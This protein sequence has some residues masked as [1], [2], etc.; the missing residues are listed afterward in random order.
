[1]AT[2]ADLDEP[3]LSMPQAT[4]EVSEDGCKLGAVTTPG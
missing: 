2:M 1:M 4:E 3:A